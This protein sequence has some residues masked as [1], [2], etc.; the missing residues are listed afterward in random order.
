MVQPKLVQIRTLNVLLSLHKKYQKT[1]GYYEK[2]PS[3]A[4]YDSATTHDH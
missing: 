3:Q 1:N 2:K 4:R